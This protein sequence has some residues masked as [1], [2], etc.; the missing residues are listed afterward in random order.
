MLS[1]AGC[2]ISKVSGASVDEDQHKDL[3]DRHGCHAVLDLLGIADF[4]ERICTIGSRAC[5]LREV[6]TPLSLDKHNNS[7]T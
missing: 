7:T 4:S 5:A 2:C 3:G 6:L 1:G